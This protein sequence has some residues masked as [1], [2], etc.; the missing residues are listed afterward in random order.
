MVRIARVLAVAALVA[1]TASAC[2]SPNF[3]YTL[4]P[5]SIRTKPVVVAKIK[6]IKID[7]RIAFRTARATLRESSYAALD[8]V[9]AVLQRNPQ[10]RQ[11]EVQGH[12]D[13]RGNARRNRL[14]SQSRANTV[15]RYLVSKGID[16]SRLVAKGYGAARPI[17]DNDSAEGRSQNRR[18][19]FHVADAKTVASR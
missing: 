16:A 18:V 7:G 1:S 12:T 8:E 13:S 5:L 2:G 15:V 4:A 10:L 17:A 9:V 3:H 6:V 19:E 11:V 14:L